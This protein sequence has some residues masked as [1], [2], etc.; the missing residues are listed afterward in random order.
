MVGDGCNRFLGANWSQNKLLTTATS[1]KPSSQQCS[2]NC[3]SLNQSYL[4]YDGGKRYMT[5]LYASERPAVCSRSSK[6]PIQS[7]FNQTNQ[8]SKYVSAS[9]VGVNM[10]GVILVPSHMSQVPC[11]QNIKN[12]GRHAQPSRFFSTHTED[13]FMNNA[14]VPKCRGCLIIALQL[15]SRFSQKYHFFTDAVFIIKL[16]KIGTTESC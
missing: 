11:N 15:H 16:Q 8:V 3:G 7:L 9:A 1:G 5:S 12:L 4:K 10:H 13:S 2:V 6:I 14:L